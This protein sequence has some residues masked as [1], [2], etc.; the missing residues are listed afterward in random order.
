[1]KP[2]DFGMMMD[3][4]CDNDGEIVSKLALNCSTK[5]VD[6]LPSPIC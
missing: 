5:W 3:L 2:R 1:M 4:E 6:A